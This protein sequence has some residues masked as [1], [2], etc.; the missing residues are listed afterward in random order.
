MSDRDDIRED[1][2]R[3]RETGGRWSETG[4]PPP[5]ATD[6]TPYE[7]LEIQN[8]E[9]RI[10]NLKVWLIPVAGIIFA[11]VFGVFVRMML[12]PPDRQEIDYGTTKFVPGESPHSTGPDSR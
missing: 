11:I 2:E 10:Q 8:P 4:D 6:Q 5:D 7:E 12:P 3:W 9:S 1:D